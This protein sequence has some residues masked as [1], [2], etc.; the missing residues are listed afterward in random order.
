MKEDKKILSVCLP[1]ETFEAVES[2]RWSLRQNRSAFVNEAISLH[3]RRM[4]RMME[5]ANDQR[6][7]RQ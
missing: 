4:K 6:S 7:K 2:L 5:R 1:M 3:V